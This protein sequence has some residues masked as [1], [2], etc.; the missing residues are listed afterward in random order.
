MAKTIL[1]SACLAGLRTRF[2]GCAR[3]HRFL[4]LLLR[5]ATVV[6]ICPEVLGGLGI[7][8]SPCRL[9]GGDGTRVLAREAQVFDYDG[10]DRTKAFLRGAWETYRLVEM[11]LPDLILFKEGSPSCGTRRV[12]INGT[13]QPGC[14]VTAALLKRTRIPI[15]AEDDPL[16]GIL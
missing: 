16:R 10:I 6:P 5:R 8:R 15:L 3:P 1:I 11:L 7:P 4:S 13:K 9:F 2:D 12:D 14:G